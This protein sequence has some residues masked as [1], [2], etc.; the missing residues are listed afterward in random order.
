MSRMELPDLEPVLPAM[1][2]QG[3]IR[4]GVSGWTYAPWRGAFYPARLPQK[5]ELSYI[6]GMFNAVEINGSFYGMQVPQS[7]ANWAAAVPE[8]TVFAVKGPRFLTHMLKL[9]RPEAPLANFIASGVLALGRHLG[10]I[11]WQFPPNFGFNPE[12]LEAFFRLLPRTGREAASL[13]LK[14]D[15]RLRAAPYLEVNGVGTI[16]HCIEIRHGSF[17]SAEFIDLLRRN[18]IALVC[19]D[20]VDWP[21]LMDLTADF[22]YCRLHGSQELYNS[23]YSSEELDR[24]AGRIRCWS[25][26]S[27]MRDGHFVT[28]PLDDGKP[29]DV[30]CFFDNTD[31]LQAPG[32]ALA[33]M[34]R[35]GME[36]TTH[37]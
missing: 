11:L 17:R 13:G 34:Q 29:R 18:D 1:A 12:R 36:R 2:G 25:T 9:N 26:G 3:D 4:I 16:R 14:H 23:A 31:K 20:T 33:L 22:V 24:W 35:L 21:L 30:F 32:N 27:A 15:E 8:D 6:A 5:R 10:P 19:A 28:P 7:F 37:G